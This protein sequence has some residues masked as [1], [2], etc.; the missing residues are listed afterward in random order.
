MKLTDKKLKEILTKENYVTAADIAKA[1][2]FSKKRKTPVVEYLLAEGYINKDILGQAIAEFYEV[3][4]SDLNS[5]QPARELVLKI[6]E[7][8]AKKFNLVLFSQD[9][10]GTT[11]TTDDPTKKGLAPALKE[12]FP[13]Q[14]GGMWLA[15]SQHQDYRKWKGEAWELSHSTARAGISGYRMFFCRLVLLGRGAI[16]TALFSMGVG[17]L[18]QGAAR[19]GAESQAKSQSHCG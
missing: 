5:N 6:P 10:E 4:Y 19:G 2:K 12:L 3:A 9:K 15:V 13:K 16:V 11:V 18:L 17:C 14:R 1:E 8:V 7:E